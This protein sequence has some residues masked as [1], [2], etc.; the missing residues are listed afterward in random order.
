MKEK[1]VDQYKNVTIY[2]VAKK[3]SVSI[4]TVSRVLNGTNNVTILKRQKVMEVIKELNFVSNKVARGLSKRRTYTIALMISDIIN[5]AFNQLIRGVQSVT[6]KNDY[7]LTLFDNQENPNK[8]S[9]ALII[10]G[11]SG[12]DGII[13]VAPR[14]SISEL[15]SFSSTQ[16]PVVVFNKGRKHHRYYSVLMNVR[17]S[18]F[19][20]TRHLIHLKHK[21]I[22]FITGPLMSESSRER[23][24]GYVAALQRHNIEVDKKIIGIGD[25]TPG[26]TYYAIKSIC[27]RTKPPTALILFNDYSAI[28]IYQFLNEKGIRIPDDI[29]IF[30]CDNI[31]YSKF[32]NPPLATMDVPYFDIGKKLANMLIGII[33][34]RPPKK[35]N[36]IITPRL[37]IR[38]SVTE[39][40]SNR[41]TSVGNKI[42]ADETI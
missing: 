7:Y 34:N 10:V 35:R 25:G 33:E 19:Q 28:G 30:A 16:I 12:V 18:T 5:P 17:H 29:S 1:I 11:N 42:R 2:D 27:K 20:A 31:T 9:Q 14:I 6:N 15:D 13:D 39:W 41:K 23:Y 8:E 22:G 21:R 3:A 32:L 24:R 37:V 4:S 36:Y 38:E 40:N 26:K